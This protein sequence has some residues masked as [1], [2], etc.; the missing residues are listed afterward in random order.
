MKSVVKWFNDE[1]GY[2]FIEY[3]GKDIFIYYSI[4]NKNKYVYV[5]LTLTDFNT[6]YKVKNIY[7]KKN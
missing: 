4:N 6:E 3:K 1:K 2:G 5:K 7:K